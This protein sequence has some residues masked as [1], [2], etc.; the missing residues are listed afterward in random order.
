VAKGNE[1]RRALQRALRALEDSAKTERWRRG[2]PYSRHEAC[3]Q[4]MRRSSRA[5]DPRTVGEWVSSGSISSIHDSNVW[6]LVKLWGEWSGQPQEKTHWDSL[7]ENSRAK[8]HTEDRSTEGAAKRAI[9]DGSEKGAETQGGGVASSNAA[10]EDLLEL[11]NVN[12][13]LQRKVALS[14]YSML[15]GVVLAL[16]A[17]VGLLLGPIS[18]SIGWPIWVPGGPTTRITLTNPY[19]LAEFA[20]LSLSGTA[21]RGCSRETETP[22]SPQTRRAICQ[23]I[24][25]LD[26]KH[27]KTI[28]YV[29]GVHIETAIHEPPS[30]WRL[31]VDVFDAGPTAPSSYV[32]A[33]GQHSPQPRST[34]QPHWEFNLTLGK[35]STSDYIFTAPEGKREIK[36]WVAIAITGTRQ[37]KVAEIFHL[38]F[39]LFSHDRKY[40]R[41]TGQFFGGSEESLV[42]IG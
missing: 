40:S 10:L 25:I 14:R 2:L 19:P 31:R 1:G 24:P 17:A 29:T 23:K 41:S 30:S 38:R 18:G 39:L 26:I 5:I 33:G 20:E 28:T 42:A 11:R 4:I 13:Y 15:F 32:M 6:M 9:L 36:A 7:I 34:P 21:G 35:S 37:I 27:H 3:K 8:S 16:I 22:S 12:K